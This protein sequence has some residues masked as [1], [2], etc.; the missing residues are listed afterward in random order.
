[1]TTLHWYSDLKDSNISVENTHMRVQ[2]EI[3]EVRLG[4]LKTMKVDNSPG[5]EG[6]VTD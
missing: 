2:T 4:L 6:S 3:K 1:M 5:S